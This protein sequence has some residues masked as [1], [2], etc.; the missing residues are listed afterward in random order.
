LMVS[1]RRQHRQIELRQV[2]FATAQICGGADP[3]LSAPP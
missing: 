3:P 2:Q 1:N